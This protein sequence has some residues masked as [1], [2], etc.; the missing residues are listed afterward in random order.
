MSILLSNYKYEDHAFETPEKCDKEMQDEKR[1]KIFLNGNII[2]LDSIHIRKKFLSIW[3]DIEWKD[4]LHI[5]SKDKL[6]GVL[7]L[8]NK[9]KFKG[10]EEL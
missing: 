2:L 9:R 4:I 3:K 8:K 7:H 5:K 1:R 10:R 6:D